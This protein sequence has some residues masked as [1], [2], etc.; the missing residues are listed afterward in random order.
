MNRTS[1]HRLAG[2]VFTKNEDGCFGIGDAF[3]EIEHLLHLVVASDDLAETEALVELCPERFVFLYDA[4]LAE[5]PF[6]G[7]GEFVLDQGLGEIVESSEA[8]GFDGVFDGPVACQEDDGRLGGVFRGPLEEIESVVIGEM[9]VANDD[10][11]L[12]FLHAIQGV[13]AG[14]GGFGLQ[15]AGTKKLGHRLTKREIVVYQQQ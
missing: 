14:R 9:D 13:L 3:D 4:S 10:I 8:N 12:P 15:T 11:E 2:T 6:D 7:E 5:R 1:G